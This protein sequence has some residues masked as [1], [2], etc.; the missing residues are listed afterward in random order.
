MNK[1]STTPY[2]LQL[3][4]DL[5]DG[6]SF[7]QS[8]VGHSLAESTIPTRSSSIASRKHVGTA[9]RRSVSRNT[10]SIAQKLKKETI[11]PW[12]Q[13]VSKG[14][15]NADFL[16]ND[17]EF[18]DHGV[19]PESILCNSEEE[20]ENTDYFETTT[21]KQLHRH[22]SMFDV[23][24][25]REATSRSP[26]K[27]DNNKRLS[28]DE[29]Q[30]SPTYPLYSMS[31]GRKSCLSVGTNRDGLTINR[32]R[33]TASMYGGR[34]GSLSQQGKREPDKNQGEVFNMCPRCKYIADQLNVP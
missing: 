27:L 1:R 32:P 24:E 22:D 25:E 20:E 7:S 15:E 19:N 12:L 2:Q 31:V 13:T 23:V 11:Q 33:D 9:N 16:A 18:T 34:M 28:L 14:D 21:E 26:H 29:C 8:N 10:P 6:T 5:G 4:L 30:R 3:N 17:D